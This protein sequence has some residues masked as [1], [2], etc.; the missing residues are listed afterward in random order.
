M[1]EETCK[2]QEY[3]WPGDPNGHVTAE[4]PA[5][6]NDTVNNIVWTKDDGITSNTGW[7]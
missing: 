4:S 5:F 7:H 6:C 2:Q 1:A 3:Q